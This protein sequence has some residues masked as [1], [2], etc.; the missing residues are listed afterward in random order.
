VHI[1]VRA[2]E[3]GKYTEI[4]I[5]VQTAKRKCKMIMR[6]AVLNIARIVG[7]E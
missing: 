2:A 3:W 1:G 6:N 5:N 4:I 7:R